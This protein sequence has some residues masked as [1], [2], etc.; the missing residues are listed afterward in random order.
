MA[1]KVEF[2]IDPRFERLMTTNPKMENKLRKAI[3]KLILE[4]RA[5]QINRILFPAIHNCFNGI[6]SYN[7][8]SIH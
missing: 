6:D 4:A 5:N 7:W 2:H 3:H 8:R 1:T